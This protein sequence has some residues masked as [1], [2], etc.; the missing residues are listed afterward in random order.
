MVSLENFYASGI[1]SGDKDPEMKVI[2]QSYVRKID[3]KIYYYNILYWCH[4]GMFQIV[5]VMT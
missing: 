3:L 2:S 5:M 4:T 1:L